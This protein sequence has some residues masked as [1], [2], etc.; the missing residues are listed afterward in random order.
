MMCSIAWECT[1]MVAMRL[2]RSRSWDPGR[3]AED[4]RNASSVDR[5]SGGTCHALEAAL[6]PPCLAISTCDDFGLGDEH[7]DG[8]VSLREPTVGEPAGHGRLGES[9]AEAPAARHPGAARGQA[10]PDDA[11]SHPEFQFRD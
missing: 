3:P 1:T 8:S 4:S 9:A 10:P 11:P 6:V 2:P 5:H 7:D